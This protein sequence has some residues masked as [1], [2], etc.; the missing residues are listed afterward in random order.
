[1]SGIKQ[2][3]DFT[4]QKGLSTLYQALGKHLKAIDSLRSL[5]EKGYAGEEEWLALGALYLKSQEWD[6][7][8]HAM[9]NAVRVS[10]A[11]PKYVYWL[12]KAEEKSGNQE[13]AEALYEQVMK[14]DND[15]W[16]AYAAKAQLIM[17]RG[18]YSEALVYFTESLLH[19]PDDAYL[20]NNVGLCLL[21]LH[22]LNGA[23][24]YLSEAVARKPLDDH[25]HY[26]YGT[27][28]LKLGE[29]EEA[30]KEF[31]MIRN[32]NN[33]LLL[34]SLGYCYG[35]LQ[36]YEESISCYQEALQLEP[37]N[38][39]CMKNLAAIFAQAKLYDQ[40]IRL[41]RRLLL[42]NPRDSELLNNAAWI[43]EAQTQYQAAEENYYRSLAASEGNPEIAYNLL[44]CLKRQKK[45]LE[46][47][48]LIEYFQKITEKQRSYWSAIAQIYEDIGASN[49][50]VDCYNKSLG[51]E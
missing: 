41:I 8:V 13:A 16:E 12:G 51:L 1:M 3:L 9:L 45:Y 23:K 21:G 28:L 46:A 20:L 4:W 19:K 14:K 5:A 24:Q 34:N 42:D 36:E 49:L 15:F 18:E 38:I 33:A 30:I 22:E 29:F 11:N 31:S 40:A 32:K 39:D 50:A 7:A 10:K 35:M 17:N 26:N 47:L 43:Y 48:D 37:N 44:C 2:K 25:L 27:V 6:K